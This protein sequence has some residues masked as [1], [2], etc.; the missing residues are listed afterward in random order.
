MDRKTCL[1]HSGNVYSCHKNTE[2]IR[3]DE[4]IK[5]ITT[6]N[7]ALSFVLRT[8]VTMQVFKWEKGQQINEA[9]EFQWGS[10]NTG[11][12]EFQGRKSKNK[13]PKLAISW[14]KIKDKIQINLILMGV[15]SRVKYYFKD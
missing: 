3:L 5:K 12:Q 4:S 11:W 15:L 14:N 2:I 8:S 1:L 10:Q 7:G 13:R 6:V 9:R